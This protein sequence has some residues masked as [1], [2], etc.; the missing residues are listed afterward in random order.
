MESNTTDIL[1]G[2]IRKE[3]G[4]NKKGL[5]QVN[6]NNDLVDDTKKEKK[7]GKKISKNSSIKKSVF[8]WN[9]SS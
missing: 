7:V 9:A 5:E 6:K 2:K 3:N 1:K 8:K 4:T